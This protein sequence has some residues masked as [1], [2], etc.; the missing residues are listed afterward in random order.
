MTV[1]TASM[2]ERCREL[3]RRRI[4]ALANCRTPDDYRQAYV[5]PPPVAL[6]WGTCWKHTVE[7]RV[8]DVAAEAGFFM[9]LFGFD[10]N[11]LSPEYVMIMGRE[12][13]FFLSFRPP[14]GGEQTTPP[15]AL[16]LEFMVA[17]VKATAAE[18]ERRGAVLTQPPEPYGAEG[19]AMVTCLLQTPHGVQVKL[20]CFY[21]D[22]A[23]SAPP[24]E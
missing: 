1:A 21:A 12:G 22:Q 3:G 20:W 19:S 16:S 18:L 11:V 10:A 5:E 2:A 8:D 24:A 13:E 14:A 9:D 7:Y 4:E 23:G 6:Q 15:D 17:D